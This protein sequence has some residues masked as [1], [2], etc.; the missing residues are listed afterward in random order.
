M[1]F[2]EVQIFVT[3]DVEVDYISF[4]LSN[5]KTTGT[6]AENEQSVFQQGGYHV[7]V[8]EDVDLN[9]PENAYFDFDDNDELV[10]WKKRV[11]TKIALESIVGI[12]KIQT[13]FNGE[14]QL[15]EIKVC[16]I[17]FWRKD[18]GQV[19]SLNRPCLRYAKHV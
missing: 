7:H 1:R 18:D 11:N 14:E 2:D 8:F 13:C 16:S 4:L 17:L 6:C 10:E 5:G 3:E 15:N 19:Y 9:L 12:D